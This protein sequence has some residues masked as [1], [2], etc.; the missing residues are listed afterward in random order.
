MKQKFYF[1]F[2]HGQHHA[3]G[4]LTNHYTI[5]EAESDA[6]A[7]GIMYKRRG[8]K[9]AFS[10]TEEQFQERVAKYNPTFISFDEVSQQ[11]GETY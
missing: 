9:W 1:T 7:S 4:L 2:G 6:E 10:Y 5:I 11:N 8:N 3:G